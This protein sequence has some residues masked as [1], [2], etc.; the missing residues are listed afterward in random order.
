MF[1]SHVWLVATILDRTGTEHLCHHREFSSRLKLIL[2]I[3]NRE[4]WKAEGACNHQLY[5]EGWRRVEGTEF[6]RESEE[7]QE[8]NCRCFAK[9]PALGPFDLG[10]S[11]FKY[12]SWKFLTQKPLHA[13]TPPQSSVWWQLQ[14]KELQGWLGAPFP[15]LHGPRVLWAPCEARHP[16]PNPELSGAQSGPHIPESLAPSQR[17]I[18]TWQCR[19]AHQ[20]L[21][22]HL[23][24]RVPKAKDIQG[25]PIAFSIWN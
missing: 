1:N 6:Q 17:E 19:T 9:G 14:I 25:N 5:R 16:T 8:T 15:P 3:G 2:A 22:V 4:F 13:S 24:L 10:T 23:E 11:S 12:Q 7:G 20:H 21:R 18:T